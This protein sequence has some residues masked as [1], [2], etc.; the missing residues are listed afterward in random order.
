MTRKNFVSRKPNIRRWSGA[1]FFVVQP[2]DKDKNVLALKLKKLFKKG[3][4]L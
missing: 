2:I 4:V 3:P 1:V